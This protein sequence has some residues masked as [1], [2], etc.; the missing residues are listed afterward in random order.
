MKLLD[1]ES[2]YKAKKLQGC[3]K[4]AVNNQAK[5]IAILPYTREIVKFTGFL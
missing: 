2:S 4:H 1:K 5:L 3:G